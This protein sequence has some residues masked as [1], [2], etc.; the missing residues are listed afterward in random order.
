MKRLI[1][2]SSLLLCSTF[3]ALAEQTVP[4]SLKEAVTVVG[5]YAVD[6]S[7]IIFDWSGV[8]VRVRFKGTRLE[9]KASDTHADYFNIWVD[10]EPVAKEDNKIRTSSDSIYVIVS[11]LKKGEHTVVLQ[12]RTEGEQ[13]CVTIESL[14]TDG[15]FLPAPGV[16]SRVIEFIG[17]S[18]TCGYGTENCTRDDPFTPETENCNLTYAEIAGRYFG[19]EA[20]HIS[21]SG[22]GVVRNY[23]SSKSPTMTTRYGQVFDL[24]PQEKWSFKGY[25][26]DIVVIYLGTNDFSTGLQPSY[27]SWKSNL[28]SMISQVRAAYSASVPV[29]VVASNASPNLAKY[30][31]HSVEGLENVHWTSVQTDAHNRDS[32]LGASWHPNYNG[33]RKVASIMI[34]Y[35]STLTGWEM[36]FKA[37]E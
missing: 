3:S 22:C 29:L 20:I 21:H 18:Y 35:I 13:G 24:N 27:E 37:Y 30:V 7:K 16:K 9:M 11:G 5:R 33:Q 1:F 15:S 8:Q 19:A 6:G 31:E 34:P 23:N 4:A 25:T 36:P 26:P 12:K 32:D 17:D 2:L 14:R 10:K 28:D